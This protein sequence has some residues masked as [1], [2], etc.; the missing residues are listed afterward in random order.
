MQGLQNLRKSKFYFDYF[1]KYWFG[2]QSDCKVV[3]L[4]MTAAK[5]AAQELI[6]Q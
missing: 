4:K 5:P 2:W 6:I 1:E 3:G